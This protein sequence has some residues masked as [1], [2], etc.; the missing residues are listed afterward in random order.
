MPV[1]QAW[2]P[3]YEGRVTEE[4]AMAVTSTP[5]RRC[6]RTMHADALDL[7]GSNAAG[8]GHFCV[9]SGQFHRESGHVRT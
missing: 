4:A 1:E 6:R 5:V 3:P 2:F 7:G 9:T 8:G